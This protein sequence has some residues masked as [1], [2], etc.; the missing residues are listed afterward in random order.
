[1]VEG[2]GYIA[3]EPMRNDTERTIEPGRL[4]SRAPTTMS[5]QTIN[6]D[7]VEIKQERESRGCGPQYLLKAPKTTGAGIL[8]TEA[9]QHGR[10][11]EELAWR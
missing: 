7:K 8:Y 9:F 4:C 11:I 2:A 6:G 1:M 3:G 10:V 5:K